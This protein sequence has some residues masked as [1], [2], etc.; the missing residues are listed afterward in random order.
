MTMKMRPKVLG[1]LIIVVLKAQNLPNKVK[2]GKQNP[3]ATLTYSIH[4]KR[5]QTIERGGQTP[6]WDDEFRFEIIDENAFAEDDDVTGKREELIPEVVSVS[7]NGAVFPVPGNGGAKLQKDGPSS[8]RREAV[9]QDK[10]LLRLACYADDPRDPTLIGEI[11]IDLEP[12]IKRGASDKWWE[13]QKKG[14][15]AGEV[16]LEMTFY[17]NAQPPPKKPQVLPSSASAYG[18]AG[19]RIEGGADEDGKDE[20]DYDEDDDP[21]RKTEFDPNYPDSDVHPLSHQM[22]NLSVRNSLPPIP[23]GINGGGGGGGG[24]SVRPSSPLYNHDPNGVQGGPSSAGGGGRPLPAVP[25][26]RN[27]YGGAGDYQMLIQQ[28]YAAQGYAYPPI[29]QSA[30]PPPHVVHSSPTSIQ[31][32]WQQTQQIY[33][34][35]TGPTYSGIPAPPLPPIPPAGSFS[36]PPIPPIPT[37]YNP[38]ATYAPAT[39]SPSP[40]VPPV[41]PPI[42][43]SFYNPNG[44]SPVE[45]T[46]STTL[47]QLGIP[48]P[49]P[50]PP[51]LLAYAGTAS[52]SNPLSGSIGVTAYPALPH[53]YPIPPV[54]PP[55]PPQPPATP[56]AY[57]TAAA[58]PTYGGYPPAPLP[59][60]VPP[61]P[62]TWG[63]AG[64]G[65]V[66]QGY[67]PMPPPPPQPPLPPNGALYRH[68]SVASSI[69][70]PLPV[71]AAGVKVD[72]GLGRYNPYHT[73][74]GQSQV[75][76]QGQGS[77]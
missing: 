76:L 36:P 75:H 65:N 15:F 23:T 63:G 29:S 35:T 45:S 61:T 77:W 12:I 5:T 47:A 43:S 50:P 9:G 4:K 40:P 1:T 25:G 68:P 49:P 53:G 19:S 18:G 8:P 56:A 41:P 72:E 55:M 59:P 20:Y 38:Y 24:G 37:P 11:M 39:F 16:Y 51:E 14:K 46:T 44:T 57:S 62:P 74:L 58:I 71:A 31:P 67:P 21:D 22:S 64:A 60:P 52:I 2:I 33:G 69:A 66:S 27:S 17:S 48:P 13:L 30:T 54:P 73:P 3:F 42:P 7:K 32:A 10:R 70:P 26:Q 28:H 6:E 34:S